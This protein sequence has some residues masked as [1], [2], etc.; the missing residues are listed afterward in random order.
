MWKDLGPIFS[1]PTEHLK[2]ENQKDGF[3]V[4]GYFSGPF[5]NILKR[6]PKNSSS[7]LDHLKKERELYLVV[8]STHSLRTSQAH[9]GTRG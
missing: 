6:L 4:N 9:Q 1:F 8:P 5:G 7:P 2:F 3:Q